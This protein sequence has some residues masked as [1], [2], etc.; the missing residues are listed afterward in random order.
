VIWETIRETSVGSM[1][2]SKIAV[3]LDMQVLGTFEV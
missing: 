2:D 3:D 1:I